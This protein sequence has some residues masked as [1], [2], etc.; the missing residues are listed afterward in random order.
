MDLDKFRSQWDDPEFEQSFA[1]LDQ[2]PPSAIVERLKSMDVRARRWRGA[3]RIM[4][5]ALLLVILVPAAVRLFVTD[6]RE[7]PLQTAAFILGMAAF[8][9][10]Q[11]LDKAREKYELPKL[12]LDHTEF[13]LDEHARMDRN[14]RLDQWTSALVCFA[15]T[16]A[17]LYAA[18]LF[19]AALQVACLAVAGAAVLILW[20]SDRRRIFQ[21][22]RSRDALAAQLR[23]LPRE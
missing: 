16:C 11:L 18:L 4:M 20:L 2:E 6:S 7:V 5:R 14:M 8:F 10:L 13:L 22:K 15:I 1:R 21:L 3:R 17:A 19:S 12:W 9:V 23:D